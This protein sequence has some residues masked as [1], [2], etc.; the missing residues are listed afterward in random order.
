MKYSVEEIARILKVKKKPLVPGGINVLLT[1]SRALFSAPDS[2][3][4]ALITNNNDGHKYVDELYQLNVRNFVVSAMN[5]R[6]ERYEDANFFLVSDTLLALQIIAANYRQRFKIPVVGITG[7]NGKTIVKEWIYQVLGTKY[8]IT[9]SP[10]SFNSQLGVPLSVWQLSEHTSLGVFEAGISKP[11]EMEKLETIIHPS[12]GIFTNL[13]QAHQEGFKH[14]KEKCLEKLDLFIHS[15]IIICEEENEILDECMQIACLSHKRFTWSRKGNDNSP[16]HI[17]KTTINDQSSTIDFSVLGMRNNITIP[18]TDYAS[19]ENAIHVLVV[20]VYLQVPAEYY[21]GKFAT[22]EAVAMRLDVRP[23]INNCSII[24]DTYNSDINSL[25]LALDFMTQRA[26]NEALRKVVILSDI[27][28]SG[29]PVRDLCYLTT[30]LLKN[31]EVNLFVGIGAN[32]CA[33]QDLF[34]HC[35]SY[36]FQHTQGFIDSG[37]YKNIKNSCVLLKGARKFSFEDLNKLFE[38]KTHETVLEIDLDAIVHNYKFYRSKLKPETKMICMVKADGYGLGSSEI[39]KTL[40]YHHADYLAVAIVEEGIAL[41]EAGIRIPIIVLNSEVGGFDELHNFCLEPEVYNFRILEAFIRE[42]KRRGV[43]HYPIHIKLDTGMHRLG[44]TEEELPQLFDILKNQ[45][46]LKVCSLFSHLAASE[47]WDFDDFTQHQIN[48]FESMT[49]QIQAH[50][51]YPIM[52]HILNSAGIERFANYQYDMVRLGISL[53]GVSASGQEGLKNVHT[54]KTTILQVKQ[55]KPGETV[56]YGRKG[57]ISKDSSIATIRIGYA[58]GLDR[59]LGNGVALAMVHGVVVPFVGN[60]CMDL[61]MID[62]SNVP[63]VKEGDI[64]TIFGDGISIVDLANK[65]GTIPYEILTSISS[66]V[67]H[68]YFKE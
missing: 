42:G 60:V 49:T 12:I 50:L 10:R 62:V 4:F 11:E 23:G 45:D 18:F 41:R 28:Q 39:A 19:I 38:Q 44:F 68:I 65:I 57:K 59:R 1:D 64:V 2:L 20:C 36:F 43:S 30:N 58:D 51:S 22:L 31:K 7:S 54:L 13:G 9:R 26:T 8:N 5:P 55:I 52:R 21:K 29:I 15:D 27:P 63:E 61:S 14:M 32:L 6:W 48:V 3:F 53:Y 47:S 24:N 34:D 66:R 17:L 40:Q 46:V 25:T 67:K 16:I 33:N 37:I 35:E 56:G